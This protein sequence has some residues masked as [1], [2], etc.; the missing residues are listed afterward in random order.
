MNRPAATQRHWQEPLGRVR[1]A[2][3]VSR[4]NAP[5][6]RRLLEGAVNCLRAHHIPSGDTRV[7]VCPGAFEL[8]QVASRLAATGSWDAIV[9]LGAVIRGETP[10][11]DY[12]CAESARGIQQVALTF[13]LPVVFGVLTTNTERQ[14]RERS[15]GKHGNKG[16]DAVVTALEMISVYRSIPGRRRRSRS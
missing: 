10:H 15:G 5:V 14:A 16:W 1:I 7:V 12:V 9:C 4:F 13:G 8:P 6:T 2:V 3:V 11:F